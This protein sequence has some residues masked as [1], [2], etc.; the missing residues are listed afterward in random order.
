M[1]GD[2]FEEL[3]GHAPMGREIRG[4]Q[5]AEPV[6]AQPLGV[7]LVQE[8]AELAGEHAR[9]GDGDVAFFRLGAGEDQPGEQQLAFQGRDRVGQVERV[10][11]PPAGLAQLQFVLVDIADRP[12]YRQQHR[13]A[14]G[15]PQEGLAQ[16]PDGTPGRQQHRHRGRAPA[17]PPPRSRRGLWRARRRTRRS[18]EW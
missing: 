16:R 11:G 10:A 12:H 5:L 2:D 13:L 7:H 4:H 8:M 9:L 6:E 15:A 3:D 14:V 17:G 1:P 18:A